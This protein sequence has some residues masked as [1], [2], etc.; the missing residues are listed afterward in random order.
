MSLLFVILWIFYFRSSGSNLI[1]SIPHLISVSINYYS[2]L[3]V[4]D[5]FFS[6]INFGQGY[7]MHAT[8][9][10]QFIVNAKD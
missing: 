4:L 10:K 8:D 9:S 2:E 5:N 7:F 1:N 3:A 6:V